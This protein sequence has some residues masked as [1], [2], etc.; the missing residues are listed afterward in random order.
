[1]KQAVHKA[2]EAKINEHKTV[3]QICRR[4]KQTINEA[5]EAESKEHWKPI[6]TKR[7]PRE[8]HPSA[9]AIFEIAIFFA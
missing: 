8:V 2:V 4:M 3:L 7:L 6:E 1:M 5:V 9:D